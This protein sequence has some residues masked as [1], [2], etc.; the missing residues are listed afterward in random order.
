VG[1]KGSGCW[2]ALLGAVA[3]AVG[4]CATDAAETGP[5][6][7]AR[8]SSA[9]ANSNP[10]YAAPASYRQLVARA[11]TDAYAKNNTPMSNILKAEITAPADG[12]MG[13]FKGGN[14]PIVCVR[15]TVKSQGL[16]SD[17]STYVAGYTFEK[18]QVAEEFFPE[19][20]NPAA[21]GALAAAI[22]NANTCGNLA[23]RAFP[24]LTRPKGR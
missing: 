1:S 13:I 3:L 12:W 16:F 7:K 2:W 15:L 22:V 4:G 20:I 5:A 10:S 6:S 19:A 14:R 21:G 18:G 17:Q 11:V 9:S 23:Y 24:E 8:A